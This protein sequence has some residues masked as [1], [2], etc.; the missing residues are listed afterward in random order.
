MKKA[1]K[2][3][4]EKVAAVV[5]EGFSVERFVESF[6]VLAEALGGPQSLK[7]LVLEMSIRGLLST[8][9]PAD[10]DAASELSGIIRDQRLAMLGNRKAGK[11]SDTEETPAS[12][13]P[14]E[15]PGSW[16]W[17]RLFELAGH[18]VD[19]TH[20]TPR[21]VEKGYDFISAK[22]VKER[23]INFEGCRQISEEEY[24]QLIKRCRPKRGD[25]LVTKSGS[26]GEVAV[27][28][29]DRDF[30]LFESVALV[31]TVPAVNP[32]Y[33]SYVVYL[34]ASGAFGAEKR[35]GIGVPHLHLVDLRELPVPL[36]PRTEQDRIVAKVE[37]LL[38]LCDALEASLRRAEDRA[39]RY[40]EAVIR[41][42]LA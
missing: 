14:H 11:A 42:L 41:E 27:V 38:S 22:D 21:Y 39:S 1:D 3:V 28:D 30:T 33:I 5:G 15:I 17:C 32:T 37:H 8:R 26:I 18:I 16:V 29:T 12:A 7:N 6:D 13:N 23:A 35:K 19:G 4:V 25:V 10:G 36:P 34:G 20:H 2:G 31:P 40:A 24:G 9:R